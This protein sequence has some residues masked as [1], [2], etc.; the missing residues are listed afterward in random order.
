MK[1]REQ[2]KWA[3][4]ESVMA[5]ACPDGRAG[6]RLR[7]ITPEHS[8]VSLLQPLMT[9]LNESCSLNSSLLGLS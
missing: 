2:L 5:A 8:A 7:E 1:Q 4:V 6:G 9:W 3:A